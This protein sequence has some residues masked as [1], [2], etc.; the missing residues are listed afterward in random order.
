MVRILFEMSAVTIFWCATYEPWRHRGSQLWVSLV[1]LVGFLL[2]WFSGI[3]N[4]FDRF[5]EI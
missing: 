1:A 4:V 3:F 2:L 5:L